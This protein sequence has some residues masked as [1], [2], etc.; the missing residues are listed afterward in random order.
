M[1]F[2]YSEFAYEA[3]SLDA[4]LDKQSVGATVPSWWMMVSAL[5]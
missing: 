1:V 2:L 5:V 4:G 3:Q